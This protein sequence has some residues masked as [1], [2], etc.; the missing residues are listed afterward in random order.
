MLGKDLYFSTRI[1]CK[2]TAPKQTRDK[3]LD[4]CFISLG[5]RSDLLQE[6]PEAFQIICVIYFEDN[7]FQSFPKDPLL[8]YAVADL[9]PGAVPE[10]IQVPRVLWESHRIFR[11]FCLCQ[12]YLAQTCR[13]IIGKKLDLTLKRS[14]QKDRVMSLPQY[15]HQP[16]YTSSVIHPGL[17]VFRKNTWKNS[18]SR[19]ENVCLRTFYLQ[20]QYITLVSQWMREASFLLYRSMNLGVQP[21]QPYYF[22]LSPAPPP[23]LKIF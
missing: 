6:G 21:K 3:T 18:N 23:F 16:Y 14:D 2:A 20:P 11:T 7:F 22:C 19:R 5:I 9:L 15:S 4:P 13:P 17:R 8:A 1:P 10:K 12:F